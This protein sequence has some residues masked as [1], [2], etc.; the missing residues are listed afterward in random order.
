MVDFYFF[1]IRSK[2][3]SYQDNDIFVSVKYLNQNQ[4]L[5]TRRI[6][7]HI[8][9]FTKMIIFLSQ[10]NILLIRIW[11]SEPEWSNS[12]FSIL[13]YWS[14]QNTNIFLV[15]GTS[16]FYFKD[17][18]SF[19]NTEFIEWKYMVTTMKIVNISLSQNLELDLSSSEA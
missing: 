12:I 5:R 18:W 7:L 19:C 11:D 2:P 9:N 14:F 10:L 3:Y 8:F 1:L 15:F 17:E 13:R 16:D 4:R 6:Q